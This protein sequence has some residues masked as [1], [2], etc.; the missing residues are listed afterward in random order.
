MRGQTVIL[1]GQSQREL[2][3][4]LIDKAPPGAV[5][6]V[7]EARRTLDQNSKLWAMLSDVSRARPQG[8][9]H[10]PET[11]KALFMHARSAEH[12]SE[13]QSLMRITT[14]AFRLKKKTH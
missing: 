8:R 12:T 4:R 7:Q 10:P 13:L 9:M 1:H 5:V 2:A 3:K 11:W 14:A 6:N